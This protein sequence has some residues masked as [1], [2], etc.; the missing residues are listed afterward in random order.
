MSTVTPRFLMATETARAMANSLLP[1]LIRDYGQPKSVRHDGEGGVEFCF[2]QA[3]STLVVGIDKIGGTS[4]RME[5]R[6]PMEAERWD[7][8]S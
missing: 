4:R 3:E 7:G 1:G 2:Q 5:E 8:M 6:E